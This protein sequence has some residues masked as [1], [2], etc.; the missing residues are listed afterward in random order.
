MLLLGDFNMPSIVWTPIENYYVSSNAHSS[1]NAQHNVFCDIIIECSL[2]QISGIKN[3]LGRQLDLIFV[4]ESAVDI[5]SQV[6]SAVAPL[7]RPDDY[8]PALEFS[9]SANIQKAPRSVS[10]NI[11]RYNF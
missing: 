5:N 6:L 11:R 4:N 7:L 9:L 8:H 3:S 1:S 2:R 10:S